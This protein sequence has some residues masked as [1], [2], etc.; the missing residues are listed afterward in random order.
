M[1]TV[2]D[3]ILLEGVTVK[4]RGI[5][6]LRDADL[7]VPPGI[8]MGIIG[9]NGA[10]KTTLIS[11]VNG[12][13]KPVAGKV[14]VLGED[15]NAL[16]MA[17]LRKLRRRTALL[18]QFSEINQLAPLSVRE[19][20]EIG[21]A[22]MRQFGGPSKKRDRKIVEEALDVFGLTEMKGR[23]YRRLSGGEQRKVHLARVFA[24]EPE[25]MLL[26]EPMASLDVTWQE[27]LRKEIQQ[28]WERTGMTTVII[29]HE[30]HHL[31]DA[32]KSITVLSGGSV[33]ASGPPEEILDREVLARAY[34]N[35]VRV[36]EQQGRTYTLGA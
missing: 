35:E 4:R 1:G 16:G 28:M 6:V 25:I 8:V 27:R 31:P 3:H 19:V 11:V 21:R 32:C 2:E 9:P 18:P 34:G 15:P 5:T 36:L 33:M 14:R 23:P 10:G 7:H 20:V 17:G 30:T 29:T 12:F 13:V 24:Q 26:D 22:G